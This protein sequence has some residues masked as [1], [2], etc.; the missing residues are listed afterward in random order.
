MCTVV[1]YVHV[2]LSELKCVSLAVTVN[3]SAGSQKTHFLKLLHSL[4]MHWHHMS[5]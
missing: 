3:P 2:W 4:P 1:R 5:L